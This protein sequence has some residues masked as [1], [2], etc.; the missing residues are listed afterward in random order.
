DGVDLLGHSMLTYIAR[1]LLIIVPMAIGISFL[2]YLAL[3][4]SPGDAVSRMLSPERTV[5]P[6]KLEALRRALGLDQPMIVRYWIWLTGVLQGTFC[7]TLAGGVPISCILTERL[8]ATLQRSGLALVLSSILGSILVT[9]SALRR[10]TA[11]VNALTG[12]GM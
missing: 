3:D 10:G 9:I 2:I 7:Y 1:R 8:P 4:L 11:T 12:A 5:D 6:V